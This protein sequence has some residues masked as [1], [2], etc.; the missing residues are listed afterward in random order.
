MCVKYTYHYMLD[1]SHKGYTWGNYLKL[2][3]YKTLFIPGGHEKPI[4]RYT[5][6]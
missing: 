3:M 5:G 1:K 4:N 6:I 2:H